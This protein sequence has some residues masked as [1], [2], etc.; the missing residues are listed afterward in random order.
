MRSNRRYFASTLLVLTITVIALLT[1]ACGGASATTTTMST[2]ASTAATT[3][4]GTTA[5]TTPGPTTTASGQ[6]FNAAQLAEF[7]GKDGRKAY[8]AVDG[9]VYDVTA[10]P[11]WAGGMH[12]NNRLSAGKDLSQEILSSP[13]GKDVLADLPKVGTYTP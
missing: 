9:I 10:V 3:M 4:P 7:D 6:T 5:A 11:Q 1:A 2:T 12:N 8:V 13:H